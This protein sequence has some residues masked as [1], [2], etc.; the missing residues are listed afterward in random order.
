MVFRIDFGPSQKIRL[1]NEK[2]S[3]TRASLR[4]DQNPPPIGVQQPIVA[5]FRPR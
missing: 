2:P 5:G 3:D 1:A 4:I